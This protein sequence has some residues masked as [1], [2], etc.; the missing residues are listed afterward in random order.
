VTSQPSRISLLVDFAFKL[1]FAKPE[2][3]AP[4]IALVNAILQTEVPIEE[5][6]L[7]N[8][9][10][11]KEFDVDKLS[12]LDIKARDARGRWFNVEMQ[13][14][15]SEG[16]CNRMVFYACSLYVQQLM[17]G[18]DY[19]EL[20]PAYTI[21][22]LDD[23]LW[24]S[25]AH[26]HHRFRFEDRRTGRTLEETIEIHFL[27]LPK[28]QTQEVELASATPVE[29][30]MYLLRHGQ[31]YSV[32]RLRELFPNREY[33]EVIDTVEEI[34]MKTEFRELYDARQKAKLDE[35][36]R[37]RAAERKGHAEG[38]E[39]GEI[40]GEI[41]GE[42]RLIHA[43]QNI[44]QVPVSDAS[45]LEGQSLEQLREMTIELQNRIQRHT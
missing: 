21:C 5:V 36:W 20:R 16:L 9:F 3:T 19:T 29:R 4:L 13:L 32:E 42:I 8:P 26:S 2:H 35:A 22:L 7:L 37:M 31:D 15:T 6:E 18:H 40:E 33:R 24:R 44:L 28:Y 11:A 23:I 27:E 38:F 41:K 30:W 1:A 10:N 43:L 34:Q 12:I 14:T 17:E 45:S 39:E 25:D